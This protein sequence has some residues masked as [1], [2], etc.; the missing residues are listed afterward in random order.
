MG[1]A[2]GANISKDSAVKKGKDIKDIK[3]IQ[4]K[5]ETLTPKLRK[6]S[7]DT[8]VIEFKKERKSTLVSGKSAQKLPNPPTIRELSK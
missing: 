3:P 7:S 1:K 2:V 8:V 4:P 6:Q 5:V